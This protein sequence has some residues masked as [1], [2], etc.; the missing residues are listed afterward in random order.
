MKVCMRTR[1]SLIFV[2]LLIT[3]PLWGQ[4][5]PSAS[6]GS[7]A[8]DDDS[9]MPLT[10]EVSGSFFPTEGSGGRTNFLSGGVTFGASYDDN[11]LTG[12]SGKP[13]SGETYSVWPTINYE[14]GTTRTRANFVYSPGFTFYEP[15]TSSNSFTQNATA[16][17]EYRLTQRMSVTFQDIFEQNSSVLAQPYNLAGTTI[18]GTGQSSTPYLIL[19]YESQI[20]DATQ[21]GLDYQFSRNGMIGASGSYSIFHYPN[22]NQEPGLY[23]S[24]AEGGSV[25][26]S[27]R[28]TPRQ[29]LG[30]TYKYST[31][32]TD[33]AD[34]SAAN[35]VNTSTVSQNGYVFYTAYI[36][37][38]YTISLSGGPEYSTTTTNLAGFTPVHSWSPS[39]V[40][41]LGWQRTHLGA[42]LAY[43]RAETSGQG[44]LGTYRADSASATFHW[45]MRPKWTSGVSVSYANIKDSTPTIAITSPDGHTIFGSA[46]LQYRITEHMSAIAEYDRLHESYGNIQAISANPDVDRVSISLNYQ[47]T[48]PLG[49]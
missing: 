44:L 32:S 34:T 46:T 6:G 20:V 5:E 30:I 45:Q 26:Y 43:A 47:F 36:A 16:D 29:F 2:F 37:H 23:D 13:I 49:R 40:A 21:A 9:M 11:Q 38:Q 14:Q 48:R 27:R 24:S 15:N 33:G 7:S 1:F 28:L 12:P 41:T 31:E 10:P 8:Q 18:S 35:D 25:Y 22:L 19:P 4:V 17:F 39:G 42:A 3:A